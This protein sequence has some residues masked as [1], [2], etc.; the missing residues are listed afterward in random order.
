VHLKRTSNSSRPALLALVAATVVALVL[1]AAVPTYSVVNRRDV[2]PK[3]DRGF[4]TYYRDV[5]GLPLRLCEDGTSRCLRANPGDLV[6]PE[7]ENFYWMATATL[8][9][10]HG[11]IDVEM[12]L[13]AAFA[14][15]R[16]IVFDRL[17]IRGHTRKGR[18]VLYHPY[19]QVRFRAIS[20]KE[21]RNVDTTHDRNCA[22]VNNGFCRHGDIRNFLRATNPPKGYV[23]F[24]NRRTHVKGGTFRNSLTLKTKG[25]KVVARTSKFAIM[26][27]RA[28]G[29][30]N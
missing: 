7:G 21:Q 20:G 25:G 24:A 5:R 4:P 26:G 12:A 22:L 11:P 17:R 9:T 14:G 13:E 18:Y 8:H 29:L 15:Q 30:A 27:K 2:G 1:A 3:D 28:G 23:G 10:P 19:G 16:P 6:P